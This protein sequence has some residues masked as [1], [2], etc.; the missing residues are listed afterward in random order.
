LERA[1]VLTEE[2][3]HDINIVHDDQELFAV[4]PS[5]Q[6]RELTKYKV[7]LTSGSCTCKDSTWSGQQC[8]HFYAAL[9]WFGKN[10]STVFES[11]IQQVVDNY[12]EN[13]A[14]Q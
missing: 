8:K 7:S 3:S 4:V 12:S 14:V 13:T 5:Q 10:F 1:L 9:I 11:E 6:G 2:F